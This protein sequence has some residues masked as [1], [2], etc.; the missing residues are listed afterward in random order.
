[1]ANLNLCRIAGLGASE[2][3]GKGGGQGKAQL[4]L[5]VVVSGELWSELSIWRQS[6]SKV[7][8][9]MNNTLYIKDTE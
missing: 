8:R 4:P 6:R 1:M 9:E 2:S 7:A 3:V 5:M